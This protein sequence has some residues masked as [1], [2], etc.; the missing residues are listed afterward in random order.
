MLSPLFLSLFRWFL[1]LVSWTL[2]LGVDAGHVMI[3]DTDLSIKYVGYWA[4]SILG[5]GANPLNSNIK[6]IFVSRNARGA[7]T[8]YAPSTSMTDVVVVAAANYSTLSDLDLGASIANSDIPPS[9]FASSTISI[10]ASGNIDPGE[11]NGISQGA[12]IGIAVCAVIFVCLVAAILFLLRQRR[13]LLGSNSGPGA[14]TDIPDA[15]VPMEMSNHEWIVMGRP[16]SP[17]PSK[18]RLGTNTTREAEAVPELSTHRNTRVISTSQ[19]SP[20]ISGTRDSS[21]E[22]APP[23]YSAHSHTSD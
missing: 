3:E 15:I 7:V 23:A 6:V 2:F 8:E 21:D 16:T 1:L 12:K 11:K 22:A 10:S 13:R 17:L 20:V 19:A 4:P 14:S 9:T 18:W 5:D